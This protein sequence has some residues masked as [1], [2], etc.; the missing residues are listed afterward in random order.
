MRAAFLRYTA[1]QSGAIYG[2]TSGYGPNARRQMD[3]EERAPDLRTLGIGVAWL[4]SREIDLHDLA[5]TVV[6]PVFR[7]AS[8][9]QPGQPAS[10][11]DITHMRLVIWPRRH[12]K[13]VIL[14]AVQHG[15]ASFQDMLN[16]SIP[17][18]LKA[19]LRSLR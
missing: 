5:R 17:I 10:E 7:S 3:E 6:V 9:Q 16:D 13:V 12:L 14:I 18:R 19:T 15:V 1:R 11:L 8:I 4:E 2:V